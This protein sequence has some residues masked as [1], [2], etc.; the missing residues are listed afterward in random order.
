MVERHDG[1]GVYTKQPIPCLILI[2]YGVVMMV[3]GAGV[4]LVMWG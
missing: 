4:A 1:K 3:V 2:M